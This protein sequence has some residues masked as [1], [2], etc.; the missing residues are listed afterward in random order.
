MSRTLPLVALALGLI[1]TGP[2]WAQEAQTP[3]NA[4]N[5]TCRTNGPNDARIEACTYVIANAQLT[6]SLLTASLSSRG[7]AHRLAG[8]RDAAMADFDA[9]LTIDPTYGFAWQ[10]RGSGANQ[11]GRA[12]WPFR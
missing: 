8:N 7:Q 9:A 2:A 11:P 3:L 5:E 6:R 10:G 12:R 1:A 4:A